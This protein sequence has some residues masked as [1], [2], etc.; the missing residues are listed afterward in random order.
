M[1]HGDSG[2]E[3]RVGRYVLRRRMFAFVQLRSVF[4]LNGRLRAWLGATR[5]SQLGLGELSDLVD[6]R[7]LSGPLMEGFL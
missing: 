5:L 4:V 7:D 6:S 2:F 3:I 1:D